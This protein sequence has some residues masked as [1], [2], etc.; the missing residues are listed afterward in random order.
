MR[1]K[2]K[3]ALNN[4]QAFEAQVAD[5]SKAVCYLPHELLIENL[6]HIDLVSNFVT[7]AWLTVT[8]ESKTNINEFYSLL[9]Q[10]FLVSM[11]GV[12][13]CF[14]HHISL[15]PFSY[16]QWYWHCLLCW[17]QYPLQY[18]ACNNVDAECQPRRHLNG[19]SIINRKATHIRAIW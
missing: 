5:L 2:W 14:V 10:I 4:S 13:S 11:F 15:L 18:K 16:F 7:D 3:Q 8:E 17:W 1:K 19:L 6:T 9:K 12:R